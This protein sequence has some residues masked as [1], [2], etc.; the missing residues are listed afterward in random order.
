M[1]KVYRKLDSDIAHRIM[2]VCEIEGINFDVW[3]AT[4]S[5]LN[6]D[7][8]IEIGMEEEDWTKFKYLI[9]IDESVEYIMRMWQETNPD[10]GG[11]C[12][13]YTKTMTIG[14]MIQDMRNEDCFDF[15][16]QNNLDVIASY[17]DFYDDIAN[18]YSGIIGIYTE[19]QYKEEKQEERRKELEVLAGELARKNKVRLD[20]FEFIRLVEEKIE[21]VEYQQKS[22]NNPERRMEEWAACRYAGVG[23]DVY[24]DDLNFENSRY[25]ERQGTYRD[26]LAWLG[27][28][29]PLL[30]AKYKEE[31]L[32]KKNR[33]VCNNVNCD[34]Y[35]CEVDG[36]HVCCKK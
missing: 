12:E 27:E 13:E 11:G 7:I 17:R 15:Q 23:Q 32:K 8:K 31:K 21:E 4:K 6:E 35:N 1:K 22:W 28:N 2:G 19:E 14:E 25:N 16:P 36:G 10:W 18:G 33:R 24:F 5:I 3:N 34:G 30:M 20:S 9:E 29:C 26:I